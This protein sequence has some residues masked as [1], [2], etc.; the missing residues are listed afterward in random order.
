MA[1]VFLNSPPHFLYLPHPPRPPSLLSIFSFVR[2]YSLLPSLGP[3]SGGS[4]VLV[5]GFGFLT[6]GSQVCK[7]RVN[8]SYTALIP[9]DVISP[10]QLK[11]TMPPQIILS[12]TGKEAKAVEFSAD[13]TTFT[14]DEVLFTYYKCVRRMFFFFF[15]IFFF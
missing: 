13:A 10:T 15:F 2:V 12:G 14:T 8:A 11:C 3:A 9:A 4:E 6:T 5:S 7:V 1:F